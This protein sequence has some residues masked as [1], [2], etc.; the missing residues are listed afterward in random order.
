MSSIA[1]T[2]LDLSEALFIPP[3]ADQY[4]DIVLGYWDYAFNR[5]DKE[6][7]TPPDASPEVE[8]AERILMEKFPRVSAA[9]DRLIIR[10][11]LHRDFKW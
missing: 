4:V 7:L 5:A 11:S 6:Y 2:K 9:V 3:E 8:E 10:R 1:P